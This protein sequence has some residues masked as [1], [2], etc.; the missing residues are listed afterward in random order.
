[1]RW[2][3][4]GFGHLDTLQLMFARAWG[5]ELELDIEALRKLCERAGVEFDA[6]W[7][8]GEDDDASLGDTQHSNQ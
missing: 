2:K 6:I 8:D 3:E 1:M 7:M 5:K 4:R